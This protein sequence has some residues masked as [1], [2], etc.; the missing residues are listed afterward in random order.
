MIIRAPFLTVNDLRI[1]ERWN[2]T[3]DPAMLIGID[4]LGLLDVLVIDYRRM[5]LQI[6]TRHNDWNRGRAGRGEMRAI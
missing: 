4:T 5:E 3:R 1:F 6:L 2:L